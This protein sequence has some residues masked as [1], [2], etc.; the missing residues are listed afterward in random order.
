MTAHEL[1]SGTT[2]R[3][4]QELLQITEPL[5]AFLSNST[6]ARRRAEPGTADLVL[7]NPHEM[8][9]P[10]FVQALQHSSQPR[11][12]DWFGYKQSEPTGRAVVA[13]SLSRRLGHLFEAEDICLTT[14]GFA[15]LAV[16]LAAVVDPGEEVVFVSPPWFFYELLIAAAGAV[17]VRVKANP[18]TFDLDPAAI[19]AAL[20]PRTRAVI[21][22]SPNNPTG[23][24][25]PPETLAALA[26]VL[27]AASARSGRPIY[28]LSDE[29]YS[30]IVFDGRSC[31]SPTSY[32]AHSLLI[33][34]YGKTLLTPG[35]R[36]GYIALAPSLPLAEREMLRQAIRL[37]QVTTGWAFPNAVLQHALPD[38]EQLSIDVGHLERKRDRLVMALRQL[39]YEVESPE[40]TFYL[41]PRSPL[42]DDLA[43]TELLAEQDVFVLPGS[44]VEMPGYIRL[45]LT[46]DDATI[47]RAL[48]GLAAVHR[49]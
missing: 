14:G 39:G 27:D 40:G 6:W 44:M 28:V 42:A 21:V 32:Y 7:G 46:A 18:S 13:A 37:A 33:Y 2:S 47:E 36:M 5:F 48:P 43:L 24:I 4:I 29:A 22:N 20:S 35:E 1:Q 41:L 9:L 34:T 19:A 3:R 38:L 12:N 31:P 49:C 26:R 8:P 11:S 30:R 23:K 10:G 16:A 15:G 45:S 17:P 25:Y